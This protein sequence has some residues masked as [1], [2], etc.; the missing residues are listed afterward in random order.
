MFCAEMELV[1]I[2]NNS[3][4]LSEGIFSRILLQVAACL[5]SASAW[6]LKY[7]IASSLVRS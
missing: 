4:S 1:A 2:L 5:I 6:S 3:S 7:S